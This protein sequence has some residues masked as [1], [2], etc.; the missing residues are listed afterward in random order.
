M[1][2]G[3]NF[4]VFKLYLNGRYEFQLQNAPETQHGKRILINCCATCSRVSVREVTYFR[5][6]SEDGD[7]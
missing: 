5:M 4:G 6:I 3:I 1:W 2:N 7:E